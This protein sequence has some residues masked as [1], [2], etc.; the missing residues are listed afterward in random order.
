MK[1][2]DNELIYNPPTINWI[3]D[4]GATYHMVPEKNVFANYSVVKGPQRVTTAGGGTLPLHGVGNVKLEH[5]GTLK[6]EVHVHGLRVHFYQYSNL[7]AIQGDALLL[8]KMTLF[9]VTRCL[10]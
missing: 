2:G 3:S 4:T 6:G 9:S 10:G 8:M 1:S 7:F 5:I